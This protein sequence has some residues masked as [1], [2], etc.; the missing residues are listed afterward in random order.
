VNDWLLR[1]R[2]LKMRSCSIQTLRLIFID[3]YRDD[4]VVVLG[5][6]TFEAA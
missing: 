3:A 4:F 2:V 5:S 6:L 1:S